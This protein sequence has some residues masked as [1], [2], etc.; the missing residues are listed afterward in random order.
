VAPNLGSQLRRRHASER[1]LEEGGELKRVCEIALAG[2][3]EF[4]RLEKKMA[5][6]HPAMSMVTGF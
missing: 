5:G 6:L 4:H 2:P 1:W 3:I